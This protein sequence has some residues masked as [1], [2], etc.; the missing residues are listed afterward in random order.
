MDKLT[1][2][3]QE[4][5]AEAISLAADRGNPQV[6][7]LHLLSALLGQQGGV[8]VALLDAVGVNRADV[9]ARTNAAIAALPGAE[10]SSVQQPSASR[11]LSRVIS[12]AGKEATALGDAYI[13]TEHL[14]MAVAASQSQAG[15]ILRAAGTDRDQLAAILP[16]VRGSA[17]VT[18]PDPEGTFQ[19]LEKYGADLTAMAREGK[20]DPVIGRDSEIRRVVQVLS[21]RTKNNAL[22]C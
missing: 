20:M 1:T 12:D 18:S 9:I 22:I 15:E 17:K 3:S 5:L 16:N 10:G 8:A 21:R 14:L 4:A 11:T 19:A 7:P 2:K 6:E 13:S